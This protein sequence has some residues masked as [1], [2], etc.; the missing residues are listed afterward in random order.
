VRSR[1]CPRIPV[2]ALF[3]N[4]EAGVSLAE[5]GD[6]R[7]A[8]P[9]GLRQNAVSYCLQALQ[10][11]E[12]MDQ[13]RFIA[14]LSEVAA[15]GQGGLQINEADTAHSLKNLPGSWSDLALACLIHVGM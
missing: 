8:Q 10:L 7:A 9:E 1:G 14:G 2:A 13:Q 15:V 3:E 11:F 12:G 6:H 4:L 5:F